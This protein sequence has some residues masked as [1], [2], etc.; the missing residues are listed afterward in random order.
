[1]RARKFFFLFL[2]TGVA[3]GATGLGPATGAAAVTGELS[4]LNVPPKS[5]NASWFKSS[6]GKLSITELIWTF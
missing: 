1:M 3:A 2:G 5:F 4:F 6:V